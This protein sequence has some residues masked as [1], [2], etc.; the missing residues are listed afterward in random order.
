M[1]NASRVRPVTPEASPILPE[2]SSTISRFESISIADTERSDATAL[3][4]SSTTL[5]TMVLV[6]LLPSASVAL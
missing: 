2:T 1:A 6:V 3:G 5:M 4:M